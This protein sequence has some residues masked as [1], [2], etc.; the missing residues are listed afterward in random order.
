MG[1]F[2]D[3][4]F[5]DPVVFGSEVGKGRKM[6]EEGRGKRDG[7]DGWIA[8]P[9][10]YLVLA[11]VFYIRAKWISYFHMY[12]CMYVCSRDGYLS[13]CSKEK[14]KETAE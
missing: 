1:V 6:E 2:L 7:M 10:M 3:P 8:G 13:P 12:S 11:A 14:G 4:P 9:R 5:V